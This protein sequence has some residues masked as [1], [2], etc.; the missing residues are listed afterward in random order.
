MPVNEP[1]GGLAITFLKSIHN[2]CLTEAPG[3]TSPKVSFKD[4]LGIGT[5]ELST[6]KQLI[7][8]NKVS[9]DD[10]NEGIPR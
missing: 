2:D 8:N 7:T 5:P 3:A 10:N 1:G 4:W 6:F 9:D